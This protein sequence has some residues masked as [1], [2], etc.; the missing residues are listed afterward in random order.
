VEALVDVTRITG[1]DV[2]REDNGLITIGCGVTHNQIVENQ[3]L[4]KKA[5]ALVEASYVVGGPQVRN[6]A[7]LG[8][9]VSHALPAADGTTALNALDAEVEVASYIGRR[10]IPFTSL[11]LGPGKS[12]IDSTRE[13]LVGVRFKATAHYEASAF[14]RIMRPQGVALPIMNMAVRVRVIDDRIDEAAIAVAPVAPTPFRCKQTEAFLKDKPATA[15]TI[16]AAIVVL[17]SECKPRTSPR[18]A[19]AEYRREVLP[20]LLR[21]TLSKAFDRAQTGVAVPEIYEVE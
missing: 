14:S 1:L 16:E 17:L 11:F 3:L 19:T 2:I 10:W 4:H 20:V 12:A 5:T 9:N 7:T 13:V 6:V 8:G 15:E 21:R 18:R